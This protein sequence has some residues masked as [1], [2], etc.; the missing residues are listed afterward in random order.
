VDELIAYLQNK[1]IVLVLLAAVAVT[2]ASFVVLPALFRPIQAIRPKEEKDQG[3][4]GAKDKKGSEHKG[5]LNKKTIIKFLLSGLLGLVV[6]GAGYLAYDFFLQPVR[7]VGAAQFKLE[8]GKN[9]SQLQKGGLSAWE[10]VEVYLLDVR[11]REKYSTEHLVG[12]E[13]LPAERAI[14]EAYPIEGVAI[15]VYSDEAAFDEA[16]K[17]AD[18]IIRNGESGKVKYDK[19]IGNIYVIKDGYEGLKKAGL[20]TESGG[21]D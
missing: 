11:S 4:K 17:V 21:W 1:P 8:K 15:A 9:I 16:R 13:S 6:L 5:F 10:R 20:S 18:A 14:S 7:I 19:K 12:S 2:I 3:K